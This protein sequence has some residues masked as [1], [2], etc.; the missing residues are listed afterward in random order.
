MSSR[1]LARTVLDGRLLRF[2][3][4]SGSAIEGYLCGM[5]D[6]H[7]MVVTSSV[8][9]HLIHKGATTHVTLLDASYDTEEKHA[10]LEA[11]VGPFRRHLENNSATQPKG[12]QC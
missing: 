7:W 11:I 1:Q 6:Y 10:D 12:E 8:E 3:L 4:T 9:K 2:S 5:D